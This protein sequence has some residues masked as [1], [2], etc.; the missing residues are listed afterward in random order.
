MIVYCCA[1]L[2]FATKIQ[3]T[4]DAL[5]LT[6]RPARNETMLQKRLDRV[7]DGKPNDAVRAVLI[8][9]D[10]GE[11]AMPLITQCKAHATEPT[12]VAWGP[13]VLVDLLK[14]AKQAGADEVMTRG[15]FSANLPALLQQLSNASA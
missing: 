9:L 15:T 7:E 5:G 2:I 10:K 8:D 4:C 13:H 6:A 3:S 12:V 11:E 1:D 14:Q